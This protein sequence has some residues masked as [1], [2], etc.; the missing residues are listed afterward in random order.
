MPLTG[1]RR[2]L[3]LER[4]VGSGATAKVW[5]G[6]WGGRSVAVKIMD[7]DEMYEEES[8]DEFRLECQGLRDCAHANVI[9]FYLEFVQ[10][11][12]ELGGGKLWLLSE[13]CAGG[14]VRELLLHSGRLSEAEMALVC[15]DVLAGLAY[16]H[17]LKRVHRDIKC[18]NLVIAD[19]G[20]APHPSASAEAVG[21]VSSRLSLGACRRGEDRRLWGGGPVLHDHPAPNHDRHA[22][23][24]GAGG[25]GRDGGGLLRE[26]G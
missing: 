22:P 21:G 4:C 17:G 14:A 8:L 10:R 26:Q 9:R 16:I 13:F 5:A 6:R 2:P 12:P 25:G 1:R 15:A 11:E 7:I 23:L 3:A 20:T 18:A 24:D 19:D